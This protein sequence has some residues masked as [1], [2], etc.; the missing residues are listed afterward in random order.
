MSRSRPPYVSGRRRATRSW[1]PRRRSPRERP[2]HE[3]RV[4]RTRRRRRAG[5]PGPAASSTPTVASMTSSSAGLIGE[6]RQRHA[7][8]V[9]EPE[10]LGH[11]ER[12]VGEVRVGCRERDAHAVARDGAQPEQPLQPGHPAA[13][14][15]T[16]LAVGTP[17]SRARNVRGTTPRNCGAPHSLRSSALGGACA[18]PSMVSKSPELKDCTT[19]ATPHAGSRPPARLRVSRGLDGRRRPHRHQRRRLAARSRSARVAD[20]RSGLSSLSR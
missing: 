18:T 5:A 3:Q 9:A 14:D 11:R 2:G 19:M 7:V 17:R 6:V 8:R 15:Q 12:P 13:D 1:R 16:L 4:E 20:H 10:R